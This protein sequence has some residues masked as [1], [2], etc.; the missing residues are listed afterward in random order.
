NWLGSTQPQPL[1][2]SGSVGLIFAKASTPHC[3]GKVVL[4]LRPFF[5]S[6]AP[7]VVSLAQLVF[8]YVETGVQLATFFEERR[9][10]VALV[11]V[12]DG[13]LLNCFWRRQTFCL[14][15]QAAL[16]GPIQD[17]RRFGSQL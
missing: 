1:P 15:R 9:Q 17:S 14:P 11:G 7:I 13:R 10:V 12:L 5:V 2:G 8:G 6:A 4:I 3:L 16:N